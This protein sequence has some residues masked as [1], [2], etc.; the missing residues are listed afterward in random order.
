[1]TLEEAASISAK[2]LLSASCHCVIVVPVDVVD[3]HDKYLLLSDN[4][5]KRADSFKSDADRASYIVAHSLKRYCLSAILDI[6]P[7]FLGFSTHSKG[8]PFCEQGGAIDFNLSHSAGWVLLGISAQANIGVD[9]EKSDREISKK[10]IDYAFTNEQVL[11]IGE[12]HKNLNAPT[13]KAIAY[14]T[15]KEA[16]S[17]TLGAGIAVGF[18]NIDCSGE[19]GVSKAYCC[20]QELLVQ[21]YYFKEVVFSSANVS[22][23]AAGIYYLSQWQSESLENLALEK[24]F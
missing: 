17:K 9:V 22:N 16:I 14:W 7:Q 24:L 20:E 10:V 6:E 4:E 8:K 11:S 21:S 3:C 12:S 2:S 5:K 19:A 1:M 13:K 23:H 18:K 15:Q